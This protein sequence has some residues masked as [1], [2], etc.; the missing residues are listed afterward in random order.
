MS[1]YVTAIL[2]D[3]AH[4][5]LTAMGETGLYGD[6]VAEHLIYVGIQNAVA[7]GFVKLPEEMA[8]EFAEV[9]D[10]HVPLFAHEDPEAIAEPPPAPAPQRTYK[11]EHC[12]DGAIIPNDLVGDACPKCGLDFLPF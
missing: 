5:L 1:S 7:A 9:P 10:A 11:C 3:K 2:N 8:A 12:K 4:A 6:N